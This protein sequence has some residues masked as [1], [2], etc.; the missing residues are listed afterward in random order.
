MRNLFPVSGLLLSVALIGA[1]F[2]TTFAADE[3]LRSY[4]EKNGIYIGAI[5]SRSTIRRTATD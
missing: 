3:T 1:G 2:A 5:L 4:A